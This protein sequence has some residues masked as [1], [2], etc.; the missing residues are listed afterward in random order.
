MAVARRLIGAELGAEHPLYERR[1]DLA[2]AVTEVV[3]NAIVHSNT[4][5]TGGQLGLLVLVGRRGVRVCVRDGGAA[6]TPHIVRAGIEAVGGRGMALVDRLADRWG[7]VAD[8]DGCVVW[9][10]LGSRADLAGEGITS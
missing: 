6:E 7:F 5:R 2:L 3:T 8:R 9:L 4:R 1:D 10:E